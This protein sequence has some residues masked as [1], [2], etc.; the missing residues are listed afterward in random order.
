MQLLEY[1]NALRT[2][3]DVP[4]NSNKDIDPIMSQ[5]SGEMKVR[6]DE[7]TSLIVTSEAMDE[8]PQFMVVKAIQLPNDKKQTLIDFVSCSHAQF[9]A[10]HTHPHPHPPTHHILTR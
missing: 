5:L 1:G 6:L 10:T 4:V 3:K 8:F 9:I 2:H 7:V